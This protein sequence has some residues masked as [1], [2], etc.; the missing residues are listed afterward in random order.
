MEVLLHSICTLSTDLHT[1]QTRK[2]IQEV[3]PTMAMANR[4]AKQSRLIA[5]KGQRKPEG[6]KSLF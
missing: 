4:F 2:V 6:C 3:S 1:S 5:T